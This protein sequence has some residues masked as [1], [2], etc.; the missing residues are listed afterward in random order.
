MHFVA[1]QYEKKILQ[2]TQVCLNRTQEHKNQTA[3]ST[4]YYLAR[5]FEGL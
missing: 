3:N 1:T 2:K 4:I 5:G